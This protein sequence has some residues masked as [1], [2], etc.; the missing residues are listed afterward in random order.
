M[1]LSI[2]EAKIIEIIKNNGFI[3]NRISRENLGFGKTKSLNLF[4]KLIDEDKIEKIGSGSV[5]NIF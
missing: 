1:I 3:T 5:L 4:N 2:D